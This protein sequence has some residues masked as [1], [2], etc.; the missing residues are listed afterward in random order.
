M[1][2]AV[3]VVGAMGRMGECVRA[4]VAK[5][6]SVQLHAA[7]EAPGHPAIGSEVADGVTV[8]DDPKTAFGGCAVA[9]DWPS[10]V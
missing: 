3:L 2:Q 5:E 9:I 1:T 10:P 6:P 8:T 4:A 7:L